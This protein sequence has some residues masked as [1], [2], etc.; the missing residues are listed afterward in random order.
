MLC[1]ELAEILRSGITAGEGFLII[2]EQESDAALKNA[3]T[4]LYEDSLTGEAVSV[5]MRKCGV[6]PEYMLRMMAVAEE[7][8][9]MEGVLRS[10]A[11]YY[12]RQV[13]LR[14]AVRS[15][16]GYPL[17]LLGI[18][19]AVF[20][21]F[22]AEVLPVFSRVF[23]QIGAQMLPAAQVFLS[24]GLWLGAARWWILGV[25]GAIALSALIV[26]LT[27]ALRAGFSA[28]VSRRFAKTKTGRAV[29]EARLAGVVS[30]AVSGT[31]DTGRA[32]LLAAEFA[33]GTPG[34]D[35]VS[36]CARR[37]GEG[38]GFAAAARETGL[39]GGVYCRMLA[40]G[41]RAGATDTIMRDVARRAQEEMERSVARLTGRV[42]PI[43]VIVLSLC[44]GLLLLSVMLPL[45]GIM[46]AL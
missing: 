3:F 6:F 25:L 24:I 36:E 9:A 2:S 26:W 8:G 11:E 20:F 32:L 21:V 28:A 18:V 1:T 44:V 29:T 16:V 5:S 10:L 27:P 12:D 23:A 34:G 37:V 42:E 45:V 15:A 30:L 35:A 41:E 38:E 46:S 13:K 14:A 33:A 4:A 39:F 7:T 22:L 43:A 19:L 31:S 17:L 40:V